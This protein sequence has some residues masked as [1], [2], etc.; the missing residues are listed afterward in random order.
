[1]LKIDHV[2]GFQEKHK[3]VLLK[4]ASKTY[5]NR[6]FRVC[7]YTCFEATLRQV[8]SLRSSAKAAQE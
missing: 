6:Y 7:E 3:L 4:I 8:Y 1:M 5:Q 2:I